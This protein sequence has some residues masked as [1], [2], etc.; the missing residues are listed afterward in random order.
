V[1]KELANEKYEEKRFSAMLG[2]VKIEEERFIVFC[3]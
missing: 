2:I 3:E 1:I